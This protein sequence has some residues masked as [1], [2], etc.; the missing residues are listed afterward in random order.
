MPEACITKDI[1][2]NEEE[3]VVKLRSCSFMNA[4]LLLTTFIF[5]LILCTAHS[6]PSC[7]AGPG[8][9]WLPGFQ[10]LCLSGICNCFG[11]PPWGPSGDTAQ[12]MVG[13]TFPSFPYSST[14][15][16]LCIEVDGSFDTIYDNSFYLLVSLTKA[17]VYVGRLGGSYPVIN[18]TTYENSFAT[19]NPNAITTLVF[20]GYNPLNLSIMSNSQNIVELAITCANL[21]SVPES[22]KH[23][24]SLKKVS[25][26][27]NNLA[28][29]EFD[30]FNIPSLSSISVDSNNIV[31]IDPQFDTWLKSTNTNMLD[32][33]YNGPF[34]C[35][36]STQWMA[37]FA[38]CS[39]IQII[40]SGKEMCQ[41]SGQPFLSYLVDYA[42]CG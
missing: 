20:N 37:N 41:S 21:Q 32:I 18:L 38:V 5:S 10:S 29:I 13:N 34:L 3:V 24:S 26:E 30:S 25:F 33:S 39:P 11:E 22:I 42:K 9:C 6:Y 2:N 4:K 14:P 40:L 35:D 7:S 36:N 17:T 8:M 19:Q 28:S 27:N 16:L 15:T 12:C 23:F 31:S 1:S